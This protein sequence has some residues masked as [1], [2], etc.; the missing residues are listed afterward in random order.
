M[1]N[2]RVDRFPRHVTIGNFHDYIGSR[3]WTLPDLT[4]KAQISKEVGAFCFWWR[5]ARI[6]AWK[7]TRN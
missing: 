7:E 5:S 3:L 1:R 4:S 2:Y 6:A